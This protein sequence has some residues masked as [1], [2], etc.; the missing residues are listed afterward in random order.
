MITRDN[1]EYLEKIAECVYKTGVRRWNIS[2]YSFT[3][4]DAVSMNRKFYYQTGIGEFSF[5][6]NIGNTPYF[7]DAEVNIIEN[8]IKWILKYY[9]KKI[10]IEGNIT[11]ISNIRGYYSLNSPNKTS[12]KCINPWV[13]LE[14][15]GN[16]DITSCFGAY[17]LGNIEND[18][19][20]QIWNGEKMNYLR[21]ILN[22]LKVFPT[23]FR[24]CALDIHFDA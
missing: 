7:T 6:D 16:G 12:S 4:S 5:G 22:K 17:K 1:F 2:H 14:I 21:T 13:G 18:S 15:R 8:K 19:I 23:C 9:R 20:K 3:T 24:C 10:Y 11:S